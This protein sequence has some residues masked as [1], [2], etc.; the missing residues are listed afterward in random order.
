ML[1]S[2]LIQINIEMENFNQMLYVYKRLFPAFLEGMSH[3]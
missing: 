2:S 1:L 3:I